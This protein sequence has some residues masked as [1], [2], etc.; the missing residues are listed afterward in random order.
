MVN[1]GHLRIPN[2]TRIKIASKLKQGV[3]IER[4][5]DD[6]R[7]NITCG[8]SRE[9]LVTRQ[10][11]R[12][13]KVQYNIDGISRHKSDP[14]S[15][16]AWVEEMKG[17][18]HNP[19]LL[20]KLQGESDP[21][22]QLSN[23]DFLLVLQ[24]EFQRDMLRQFR[25]NV[26]CVDSTYGTNAYYFSLITLM[27]IDEFGEGIPVA[28]AISNKEETKTLTLFFA[29][30][31][32][33]SGPLNPK[34]FMSDDADQFYNAWKAAFGVEGCSKLLCVWHVDRSW[35]RALQDKVPNITRRIEVY[36]HLRVLLHETVEAKF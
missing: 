5:L 32:A 16:A 26:V 27:V 12:N 18:L 25:N 8:I 2:D 13:I 36:H 21:Q 1:L 24:I 7:D 20:F 29:A 10:D 4:I 11:I 31:K 35:R 9:H 28:W 3:E 14:I 23:D 33:A 15:V 30:I 34:W 22:G 17:L 19:V 6:I